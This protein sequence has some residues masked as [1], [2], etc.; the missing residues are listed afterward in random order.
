MY[1]IYFIDKI[2]KQETI[3]IEFVCFLTLQT[4]SS[5]HILGLLV[6]WHHDWSAGQSALIS[7]IYRHTV[8]GPGFK[9]KISESSC[10]GPW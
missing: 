9:F 8:T 10:H 7:S 1:L 5:L 4:N 3:E 2:Q 6:Y